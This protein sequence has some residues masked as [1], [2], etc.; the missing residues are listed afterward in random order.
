MQWNSNRPTVF[1]GKHH[2]KLHV[3]DKTYSVKYDMKRFLFLN[4]HNTDSYWLP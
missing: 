2:I 1:I 4:I 3:K